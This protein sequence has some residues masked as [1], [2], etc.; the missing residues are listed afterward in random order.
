MRLC[1]EK[2]TEHW[3]TASGHLNRIRDAFSGQGLTP[4]LFYVGAAIE[5][6][7]AAEMWQWLASGKLANAANLTNDDQVASLVAWLCNL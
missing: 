4:S 3:K 2:S 7:M 5:K 6:S 1:L